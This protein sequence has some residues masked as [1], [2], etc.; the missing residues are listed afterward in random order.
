M[1]TNG[2]L[3]NVFISFEDLFKDKITEESGI[4]PFLFLILCIFVC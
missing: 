2:S 4:D 1:D 3:L